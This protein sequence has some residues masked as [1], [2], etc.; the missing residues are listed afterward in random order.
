MPVDIGSWREHTLFPAGS[1][2]WELSS[3]GDHL[4]V[5]NERNL[6]DPNDDAV[7]ELDTAGNLVHTYET[8]GQLH[9]AIGA[10]GRGYVSRSHLN[11]Q[12][13]E[14]VVLDPA[15]QSFHSITVGA[16][17][18]GMTISENKLYVVC[19]D[20]QRIDIVDLA[21]ETVT[22]SVDLAHTNPPIQNP[23][24]LAVAPNGDIYVKAVSSGATPAA[25]LAGVL[26]VVTP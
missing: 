12:T 20:A 4:V 24:G 7:L 16:G 14:V 9:E 19:T 13:G 25:P 15:A 26:Y 17:A 2:P 21:T 3:M 8:G 23:R 1:G 18:S 6:G 10:H 11:G 5:I 22:G